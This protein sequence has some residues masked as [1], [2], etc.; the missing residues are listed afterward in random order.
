MGPCKKFLTKQYYYGIIKVEGGDEVGWKEENPIS[1]RKQRIRFRITK[2][3]QE[4]NRLIWGDGSKEEIKVVQEEID[5]L[6]KEYQELQ[7]S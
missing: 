7:G 5:K 3:R 6:E 2:L 4:R 1:Y